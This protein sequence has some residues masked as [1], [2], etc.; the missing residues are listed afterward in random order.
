MS[1]QTVPLIITVYLIFEKKKRVQPP[2]RNNG[3]NPDLP[4]VTNGRNGIF[5]VCFYRPHLK[6]GEG[7]VF[8]L[9]TVGGSTPVPF[10]FPGH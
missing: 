1:F 10:Y 3:L 6:D 2:C 5:K 9:F 8:T 7:N 4:H